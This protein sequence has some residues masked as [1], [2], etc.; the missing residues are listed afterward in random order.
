MWETLL[1][2]LL[3]LLAALVLGALAERLKQ[4]AILGYLLA[5]TLLG[6][7]AL[8][9]VSSHSDDAVAAGPGLVEVL[10]ELGVALLLFSIGLEFSFRRL[11]R[12]GPAALG[13]G[14]L[15]V[16]VT[17]ALGAGVALAGGL[18]LKTALAVGAIV[19]LSST[20][21]VLRVL[22]SRAE[23]ESI[24][25]RLATG[26]LLVQDLAVVPLVLF[27]GILGGES[28]G[29]AMLLDA[30]RKIIAAVA[31][32]SG[33]WVL[34]NYVVPW[35]LGTDLMRR[36][37]ELPILI[38]IVAGLGSAMTTHRLGLSA[39]LGAFIVGMILAESP[40]AVQIRAD[41]SS[42]RT[43]LL[44]LFFSSIGMLGDPS[45]AFRNAPLVIAVVIA[46]VIGK[47]LITWFVLRLMRVRHRHGLAAGISLAQA[48][49]FSFVLAAVA[50]AGNLI[51]DALLNLLVT[52]TIATLFMTPY[53]VAAAPAVA[54][55]VTSQLR[56]MRLI[57]PVIDPAVKSSIG[58]H[59]R[60]VIIIGFGP[61]GQAIGETMINR[62][63]FV[64]V[65]ELNHAAVTEARRL[66]FHAYYGD[67]TH[68]EVLEHVHAASAAAVVITIPDPNGA[69]RIILSLRALS[70]DIFIIVRARYHLYRWELQ[71][72]GADVVIDEE[73]QLGIHVAAEL[74]HYLGTLSRS[75]DPPTSV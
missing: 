4:S 66:G 39:S 55:L 3:L 64:H 58:A 63:D 21:C 59:D 7:N 65:I 1:Q 20:A 51:N 38:A 12:L 46:I 29:G 74:H 71:H 5:G 37:R 52:A 19:T 26:I 72:A 54:H 44:T 57:K 41:I 56:R 31:L 47:L 42:L 53:L 34:F 62:A 32:I 9:L 17:V 68:A 18:S 43:L 45:W 30:G 69:R 27:L 6:P 13:G 14:A 10:A 2:I 36:N 73:Y 75:E 50:V 35:V 28:D 11:R 48:G 24:H 49:E 67:A 25:G 70:P 23:L 22:L 60:H 16:V 15:Q 8:N 61:A 40:F 33:F